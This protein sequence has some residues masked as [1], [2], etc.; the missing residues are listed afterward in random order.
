MA[1]ILAF[2]VFFMSFLIAGAQSPLTVSESDVRADLLKSFTSPYLVHRWE[3]YE[4]TIDAWK[5]WDVADNYSFGP[6]RGNIT[7]ITDL[8][9]LHPYFRDKVLELI[10]Q[11]KMKGIQLAIVETYR[12]P[13]KQSE[14]KMKG[15]RYTKAGPGQS[16]HQ[17]GLA[18]DV[19]PMIDSVPQWKSVALWRK[20]GVIGEK[21]GMTWGGRWRRI[22]D[23]GHFEWTGG[24]GV[25]S[26]AQGVFP[27]IPK[28]ENYPCLEE[29]MKELQR[30]WKAW[31]IQ[32]AEVAR[33]AEVKSPS[34]KS[35]GNGAGN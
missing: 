9:S 3:I 20:I 21:L 1:K 24:L 35:S 28:P 13:A 18:V 11:C 4:D 5:H 25:H 30:H 33:R 10:R 34:L 14:Y 17:Y 22:Y 31:Q 15:R 23:P 2:S 19:V 27:A 7:M 29:D 8:Q 26:L 16:K 12:T 6:D 32:Q